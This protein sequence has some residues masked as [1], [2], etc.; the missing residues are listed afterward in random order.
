MENFPPG[1][2]FTVIKPDFSWRKAAYVIQEY[3][4]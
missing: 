1:E 4:K 2:E 3:Y